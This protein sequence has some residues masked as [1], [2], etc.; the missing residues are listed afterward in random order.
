MKRHL[1][2]ILAILA[3]LA[4]FTTVA[5]AKDDYV[6]SRS[7]TAGR[8]GNS[9]DGS[10]PAARAVLG[11][12]ALETSKTSHPNT[13]S[14][15]YRLGEEHQLSPD[16]NGERFQPAVAY[17]HVHGEYLVVWQNTWPGG[18][19]DIYARRVSDTGQ[20]LSWFCVTTGLNDRA[21]PAVA[22]NASN[23]E[24][25]VVWMQEAA[26]DVYEIW[27]R[28]IPW[29][30]PG[31]NPDFLIISW[32]NRSF[33]TPKVAWNSFRNEYL[34]VWNAFDTT[35]GFPPGTANDIAGYRMSASGVVQDP[36]FPLIIAFG[37]E[38]HQVDVAYNVAMD[39]YFFV[40]VITHTQVTTGN[41][42]YGRRVS[43]NGTPV[44]PPGLIPICEIEK[45]QNA[46]AVATNG[47]DRYMVVWEHAYSSADTDIYGREYNAD[48]SPV[49]S[50]FTIAS[51]TE[52]T[53]T[54]D[55]AAKGANTEWL[56]VWQEELSSGTEYAVKGFR[57]RSEPAVPTYFFD[58]ANYAFW[59]NED[60]AAAAGSSG[61]LI[62]YEGDSAVTNR[63]IFGRVWWPEALYLPLVFR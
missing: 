6:F 61:Y 47:Q 52:D 16:G 46:P 7:V 23:D 22:Y 41:D 58:V 13:A 36:G 15:S 62:A 17:N 38:P 20:V 14:F 19:R 49:G 34:V 45:N 33:W 27:G 5:V 60:P 54:P 28:I 44:N 48:G 35:I 37:S 57:W 8:G 63:H 51:W 12:E 39:E 9:A 2:F 26:P 4:V 18:S 55:V 24:Y 21:Q 43:W 3:L 59:E 1:P 29:N 32:V 40:F 31:V 56:A 42:I 30:A 50:Y 53:T 10:I 25:L 11:G